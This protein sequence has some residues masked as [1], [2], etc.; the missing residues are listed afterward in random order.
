M[1]SIT[2]SQQVSR[3]FPVGRLVIVCD[4]SDDCFVVRKLLDT[5][6]GV[7]GHTA[8]SEQGVE[9]GAEH[10]SLWYASA[11]GQGGEQIPTYTM[12][13]GC[14]V[15]GQEVYSVIQLQI[16]VFSLSSRVYSFIV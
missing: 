15:V 13:L 9:E 4:Q 8:I 2:P 11:Q 14:L 7:N 5:V 3:L 6:G 1:F 12:V 10:T 16:D